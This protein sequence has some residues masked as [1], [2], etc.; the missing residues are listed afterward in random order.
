MFRYLKKISMGR[1]AWLLML[2]IT[3]GLQISALF[4]Q[5]V[6]NMQPCVLCIYQ[7]TALY[8]VL[9]ASIIGLIAPK[10]LL[11]RLLAISTWLYSAAYG[12]SFSWQHVRLQFYSSPLDTCDLFPIFYFNIKWDEIVPVIFKASG[13]CSDKLGTILG[14]EMSQW[15]LIIFSAYFIVGLAVLCSQIVKVKA[16]KA[17]FSFKK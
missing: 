15:M 4:F 2:I 12:M 14:L 9:L 13:N 5:H 7:R 11:I 6:L 10:S 1:G 16:Q 8:G 17:I 3:S